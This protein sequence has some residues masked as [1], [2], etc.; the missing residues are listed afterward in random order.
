VSGVLLAAALSALAAAAAQPAALKP[1][2]AGLGFLLGDWSS[3]KGQVAETGGASEGASRFTPE[4]G[5]AVIL[6]RD[7]TGLFDRAGKP[8]GGFDQ[9]MMIYPDAGGVHADY[10]DGSHVI[11]YVSAQ[12]TP[13]RAVVFTSAAAPGQPVFRLSY[14]LKGP[15]T[16]AVDFSLQP[17]GAAAF[18]PIATGTLSR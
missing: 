10:S 2:L 1:D 18:Q 16:L 6:R 3:G 11:H 17:P 4:A 15:K 9:I 7:H 8:T 13:G 12:V 14:D 5:G